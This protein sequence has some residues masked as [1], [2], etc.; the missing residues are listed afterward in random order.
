[1]KRKQS[2]T[3]KETMLSFPNTQE[4]NLDK[5]RQKRV[6]HLAHAPSWNRIEIRDSLDIHA[7]V[8]EFLPIYLADLREGKDV[9]AKH[10]EIS[11]HLRS[12]DE[13]RIHFEVLRE[14]ATTMQEHPPQAE[15]PKYPAPLWR[16]TEFPSGTGKNPRIQFVLNPHFWRQSHTHSFLTRSAN[17]T[18]RILLLYD[19]WVIG[20]H[21]IPIQVWLD[22][23]RAS[24]S[25]ILVVEAAATWLHRRHVR[26]ILEAGSQRFERKI[27]R[28]VATFQDVGVGAADKPFT[29]TL[30]L[31][32]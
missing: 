32:K 16:K 15:S 17:E 26:A 8:Q 10:A 11:N 7:T 22:T 31:S 23:L 28:G 30:E 20:R 24:A 3:K 27:S 2:G 9:D 18:E 14:I 5:V 19:E 4:K 6:K 12:C 13:C 21:S 1:M 29:L 25:A